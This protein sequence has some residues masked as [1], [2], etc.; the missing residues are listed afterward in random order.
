M[1]TKVCLTEDPSIG[2]ELLQKLDSLYYFHHK[3]WWSHRRMYYHLRHCH[4][5]LN[6]ASLLVMV[7]GM[8]EG[9]VFVNS[10]IVTILS[11]VGTVIKGWN[12]SKNS[13]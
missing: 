3:Q 1:A 10:T 5:F 11:A 12:V 7:V 8:I 13:P 9:S 2:G 6:R 4:G